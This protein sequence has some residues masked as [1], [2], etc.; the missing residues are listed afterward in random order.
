MI[1]Y[2]PNRLSLSASLKDEQIFHSI[3]DL[4]LYIYEKAVRIALFI[5]SEPPVPSDFTVCAFSDYNLL[6]G[7]RNE[8]VIMFRST[9]C[10]GY[11]GE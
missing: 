5:G 7:Y 6:T 3:D 1:R 2:R 10:V 4:L 9:K 11:C 8:C